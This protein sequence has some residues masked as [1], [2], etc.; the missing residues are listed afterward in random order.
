MGIKK[1]ISTSIRQYLNEN[2][3]ELDLTTFQDYVVQN[4][5]KGGFLTSDEVSELNTEI[6]NNYSDGP[7]FGS[8]NKDIRTNMFNY[9]NPLIKKNLNGVNLRVAHGFIDDVQG[10]KKISYLLYADG[11]IIG[12]FY[13]REDIEKII[14]Y[15]E[16]NIIKKLG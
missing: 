10:E 4:N 15:I 8:L 9:D 7:T 14:N 2:S 6:E 3:S 5:I 13:S 12:K 11:E 16:K 1:F